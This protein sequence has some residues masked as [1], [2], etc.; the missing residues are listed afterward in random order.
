MQTTCAL[1]HCACMNKHSLSSLCGSVPLGASQAKLIQDERKRVTI[2]P[3]TVP[4][5]GCED[6][7]LERVRPTLR[8]RSLSLLSTFLFSAFCSLLIKHYSI[9]AILAL[10]RAFLSAALNPLAVR[11]QVP[12]HIVLFSS[13]VRRKNKNYGIHV[14]DI[15]LCQL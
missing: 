15:T 5:A 9:H 4:R 3:L 6:S 1:S 7:G 2:H 12:N 10:V 11:S 14:V 8:H 13:A